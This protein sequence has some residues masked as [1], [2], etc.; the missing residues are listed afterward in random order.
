MNISPCYVLL[1]EE[2][3]PA[4]IVGRRYPP[5]NQMIIES[6]LLFSFFGIFISYI[7]NRDRLEAGLTNLTSGSL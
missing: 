1:V 4:H 3:D 5:F 6:H 2:G 7:S